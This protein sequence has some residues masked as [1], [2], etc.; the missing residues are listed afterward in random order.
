MVGVRGGCIFVVCRWVLFLSS[1]FSLCGSVCFVL[2][3]RCCCGFG[4]VGV[5]VG[6]VFG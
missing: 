2:F 3:V 1:S 4:E 5:V 6:V